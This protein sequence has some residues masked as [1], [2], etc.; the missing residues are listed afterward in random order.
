MISQET[1]KNYLVADILAH[2]IWEITWYGMEKE[3]EKEKKEIF[4]RVDE[5]TKEV[6]KKKKEEAKKK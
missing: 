3:M 2:F 5:I 1:L 6:K 4:K